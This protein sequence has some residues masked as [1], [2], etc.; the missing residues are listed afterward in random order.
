MT[1]AL[2]A[3]TPLIAGVM[4]LFGAPLTTHLPETILCAA[5]LALL[6]IPQLVYTNGVDSEKWRKIGALMAP[7]DA[8]YGASF[9]TLAGAWIGAIPIPL[10]WYDELTIAGNWILTCYRDRDWQRWP[11]TIIAGAYAGWALGGFVGRY[12]IKG[13]T[14]DLST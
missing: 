11:C 9:G 4:I 8:V 6:S 3:G 2:L 10:D 5:H 13:K 14:V 1:L 7:I 12:V